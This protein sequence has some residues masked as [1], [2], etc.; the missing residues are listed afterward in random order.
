MIPINY[1][2][3]SQ[4]KWKSP[5]LVDT[6]THPIDRGLKTPSISYIWDFNREFDEMFWKKW[7]FNL[8]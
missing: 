1:R 8:I 7:T 5:K 4:K 6:P 3:A 2:I